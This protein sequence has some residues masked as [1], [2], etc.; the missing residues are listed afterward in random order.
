[1]P[2]T[3]LPTATLLCPDGQLLEAC[4]KSSRSRRSQRQRLLSLTKSPSI[5]AIASHGTLR[6]FNSQFNVACDCF[7]RLSLKPG[8]AAIWNVGGSRQ[9][10]L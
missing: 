7:R 3:I 1:M 2:K 4:P 8:S 9:L 5:Y 6:S 10:P